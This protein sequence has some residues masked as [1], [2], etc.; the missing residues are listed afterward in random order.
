MPKVKSL[1]A[2]VALETKINKLNVPTDPETAP[3]A[4]CGLGALEEE[5]TVIMGRPRYTT[6][7]GC[8]KTTWV[9]KLF[10]MRKDL[11]IITTLETVRDLRE[12][13]AIRLGT[14][15]ITKVRTTVS[16]LLLISWFLNGF[17][18]PKS[19]DRLIV[20]EALMSHI[21]AVVMVIRLVR[22]LQ[23]KKYSDTKIMKDLPKTLYLT[24]S[25]VEKE[26]LI[27]QGFGKG[28]GSRVLIIREAQG[29][30]SEGTVIMRVTAKQ[31]LHDTVPHA[32]VAFSANPLV[33]F[34]IR[35][36]V[37]MADSSIEP[38][39]PVIKKYTTKMPRWLFATGIE[40]L[41]TSW[42]ADKAISSTKTRLQA[43][44]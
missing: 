34:I 40:R 39:L 24:Y 38:W 41:W 42:K 8:R 16:V 10:E 15:D 4:T 20:D 29:L 32:V 25:Q 33:V 22:F 5:Q 2:T 28:E 27:A 31:K 12:K 3:T 44:S 17:L 18:G 43:I 9:V 35:T 19:C 1:R 11:V 6:P 14:D 23:L 21:G 7:L 13:L 26:S 30:T 37:K 36:M